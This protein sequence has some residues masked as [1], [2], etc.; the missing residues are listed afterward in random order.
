[1]IGI[2]KITNPKNKVYIG[3]SINLSYRFKKYKQLQCKN[4]KLL[5]N[6]FIKYGIK[7]HKF[8]IIE[9]CIIDLL[10]ERERYWQE[11]YNVLHDGLNCSLVSTKNK[12]YIHS[13]ETKKK[14]SLANNGKK[15]TESFRL[16]MRNK[17]IN[18]SDETRK[19]MSESAKNKIIT[20][21]HRNNINKSKN[22]VVQKRFNVLNIESG[23]FH[24]SIP[25]ASIVYGY[26]Y[27][28][29]K[30]MLIGKLKNKTNLIYIK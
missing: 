9:E 17:M 7:N 19:K 26:K 6:S 25:V 21:E 8:E 12:K 14:I 20:T 2:Y 24:E 10:N 30:A 5:Y 4:Q 28:Y 3:Q 13:E 22:G 23:V 16:L 11:Y 18:I 15:R 27:G 29:L 1:M